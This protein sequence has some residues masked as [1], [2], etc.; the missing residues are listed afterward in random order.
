M[1]KKQGGKCPLTGKNIPQEQIQNHDLWHAD[2]IVPYSKGG[3]TT[4]ENG[5]LVCKK[6]NLSKGS[7]TLKAA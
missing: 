4:L 3:Q 1:W 7:K 6:A 5:Q 2:H